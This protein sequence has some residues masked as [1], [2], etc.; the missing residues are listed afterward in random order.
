MLTSPTKQWWKLQD[1]YYRESL[2]KLKRDC[3]Y[4]FLQ[5]FCSFRCYIERENWNQSTDHIVLRMTVTAYRGTSVRGL[6]YRLGSHC[7]LKSTMTENCWSNNVPQGGPRCQQTYSKFVKKNVE[8]VVCPLIQVVV[9][10]YT[11]YLFRS[12][13]FYLKAV[14]GISAAIV[15]NPQKPL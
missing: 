2:R 11:N 4:F 1:N 3:L 14:W 15:E 8:K 9:I 5:W 12:P 10:P 13:N 7:W 6:W